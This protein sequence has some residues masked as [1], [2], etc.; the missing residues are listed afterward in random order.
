MGRCDER[1]GL[2]LEVA[3]DVGE[4]VPGDKVERQSG[5]KLRA[6]HERRSTHGLQLRTI[7]RLLRPTFS[8]SK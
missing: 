8:S 1:L 2:V 4:D 5:L 7:S 6:I 3:L